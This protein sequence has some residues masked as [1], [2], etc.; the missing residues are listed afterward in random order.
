MATVSLQSKAH[1]HLLDII[2]KLRSRGIG[3]YVDLPEIIVTG[4]QSAGKSSVLEA[5]SGMTFPTKDNLCTQFATELILRRAPHVDVK[6]SITPDTDRS[7]QEKGQLKLF[8]PIVDPLDPR[9]GDVIEGAKGAMGLDGPKMVFSNDIL[10]VEISGPEQPH[11]TMVDLPGLFQ[12]GNSTQSDEDAEVVTDM[13]L[14]YMKR[15][16]SI[17]LAVV[18]AKSD[19]ALQKVTRLA[20]ELDPSGI[21]TLGLITKPDTL[22]EG[23][24]SEAAYVQLAQNKDV[25]FRLGWHVLKNRDYKMRNST[26][27]ERDEAE[28]AFFSKGAWTAID[29]SRLGVATLNPRLSNVL[30][31]QILLQLPSLLIDVSDGIKVCKERL[32]KLGTPRGSIREQRRY[33]L[34]TSQSF[35]RLMAVAVDGIYNDRFFGSAK[36]DEG[37][38]RR[39]RAVVQN[40]LT[41]FKNKMVKHGRGR[42]IVDCKNQDDEILPSNEVLR[43]DY[44]KEVK[45][46]IRRSRGCELPGTFN[47]LIVGE[48]FADQC[49]PWSAIATALKDD[50]LRAAYETSNEAIY[51]VAAEETAEK[52]LHVLN[53]GIEELKQGLDAAF[54]QVMQPYQS[55]HPITYNHHLTNKVEEAQRQRR[56]REISSHIQA[57][58]HTDV[59]GTRETLHI[60]SSELSSLLAAQNEGDMEI[61]G[62]SL[63][64]DYMEAYYEVA[65]ETFVDNISTL[66]IECCLM[67][68][69]PSVFDPAKTHDLSDEEVARLASED[70]ASVH[71][72]TRNAEKLAVLETALRELKCLDNFRAI[73]AGKSIPLVPGSEPAGK[74]PHA[75][76]DE[77]DPHA[78][79]DEGYRHGNHEPFNFE[80]GSRPSFSAGESNGYAAEEEKRLALPDTAPASSQEAP[81]AFEEPDPWVRSG[82]VTKKGKKM[83]KRTVGTIWGEPAPAP[84]K[85]DDE[86]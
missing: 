84:A 86:N 5:I 72:R 77:G 20:R 76:V 47:A 78:P 27:A 18:S 4:D 39:L 67:Q 30:K 43:S 26:S 66:T 81:R 2:D 17:I 69:L 15:P 58:Y 22:D 75:P 74:P 55:L 36:T 44:V 70:D 11:L 34:Q 9:I 51:H 64:V 63:A 49:R 32:E 29:P 85:G 82:M 45:D 79:V 65:L 40:A 23:S 13:V 56:R 71:E 16:R 68:K 14:R 12:A 19:F 46:L 59:F 7:E 1:R 24:D 28:D 10:R 41:D 37:Y 38:R 61:Y 60:N 6:V 31:D 8:N 57:V 62:S 53:A 21:R 50:I 83:K 25:R 42:R 3:R 73:A 52:I 33:L 35:S 48:L 54:A 80:K